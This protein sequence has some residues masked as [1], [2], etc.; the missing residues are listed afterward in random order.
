M[1]TSDFRAALLIIGVLLCQQSG[2]QES[3]RVERLLDRPIISPDLDASIGINIQGPSLIRV[4]DWIDSPLGRYYL[5]FADHKGEYIRLAF[6][7]ELT[8]PWQIHVPGSVQIADSC[9]LTKAPDVSAEQLAKIQAYLESNDIRL[10]HDLASEVTTPHIASP[11]VHV[12][13]VNKKIRMYFHGLDN[14]ATQFTR[15]A[16]STDGI[17]FVTRPERLGNTYMKTFDWA[18]HTY[19]MAMPGQFYRSEDGV[20]NFVKGPKLFGSDMRHAA[21]LVRDQTLFVFWTRVGDVPETIKLSKIDLTD[22]WMG[23]QES[24]SIE[25]LRP[26]R[27]WEG[28]DAPLEAS[29]R[30]TAYGHVNQL[31]DPAIYEEDG[32]MFLLYAVAG[33]SGVGI[34]ELFIDK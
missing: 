27:K 22:D 8:G 34:A 32:R 24:E 25:V 12:D 14:V 19:A 30:S 4:P 7:N 11:D 9:F 6:A 21:L 3:V 16:E 2:A 18:G 26:E 13:I 10:S 20:T 15:V 23:W 5:Y 33:E 1:S 31:R 28:A 17:R 29:V